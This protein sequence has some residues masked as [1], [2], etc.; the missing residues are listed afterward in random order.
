MAVW[1]EVCIWEQGARELPGGPAP[2]GFSRPSGVE[3]E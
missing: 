2:A 1:F 3:V